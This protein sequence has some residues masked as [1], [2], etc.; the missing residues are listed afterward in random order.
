M[1]FKTLSNQK[2]IIF[3]G[4]LFFIVFSFYI[5]SKYSS[6]LAGIHDLSQS[7][8]G[9]LISF[10]SNA[11]SP[12]EQGQERF[13]LPAAPTGEPI[14]LKIS[15]LKVDAAVEP[16]GLNQNGL[17]DIPKDPNNVAW[18]N[19][20][21]HPGENGSAVI[22]G[23]SGW[24]DGRALVF[25][26]LSKLSKGDLVNIEDD[27]GKVIT[28]IVRE[29]RKYDPK[30]DTTDIFGSSD[31]KVHLN[32]FTCDGTWNDTSSSYPDRLVVFTDKEQ[33]SELSKFWVKVGKD[34][35]GMGEMG[36]DQTIMSEKIDIAHIAKLSRL[37]LTE[38]E[39]E[40]YGSQLPRILEYVSKLSE[41][42]LGNSDRSIGIEGS[43][44]EQVGVTNNREFVNIGIINGITDSMREDEVGE[45]L[46]REEAL[47][48]APA[49]KDGFIAVKAVFTS[50]NS[51]GTI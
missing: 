47:K 22:A 23:H 1:L 33:A 43:S 4:I 21:P 25:D 18:F 7:V 37:D 34:I 9:G 19:L 3:V 17:M 14:R 38:E 40:K 50:D 16:V 10:V 45:S 44:D 30:A 27:K 13:M 12:L 42:Q 39:L 31:G 6:L 48:N 32:L 15:K 26:N 5:I 2:I 28:F 11:V 29:S 24:K 36:Y 46:T 49:Q 41:A 8:R 51:D 35:A 20:G